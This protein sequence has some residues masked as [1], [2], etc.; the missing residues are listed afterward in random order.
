MKYRKTLKIVFLACII[1][2]MLLISTI[3]AS[4]ASAR[5]AVDGVVVVVDI[6][7]GGYGTGFA[8][9]ETGKKVEYI[10]TNYH[11]VQY[12]YENHTQIQVVFSAASNDIVQAEVYSVNQKKDL[13][14]VKLPEPTDKRTALALCPRKKV[15]ID[16]DFTAL[17]FPG[18]S[19]QED[20]L[21]FDKSSITI[22]SAKIAKESRIA[23][24]ECYL[25]DGKISEGNSGGP[26]VNAQGQV[27]GINSFYILSQNGEGSAVIQDNYAI[28]VD[29]LL[30]MIDRNDIAIM[31]VGEITMLT[32]VYIIAAIVA[33]AIIAVVIVLM[34]KKKTAPAAVPPAVQ[35]VPQP[36]PE[37]VSEPVQQYPQ[38]HVPAHTAPVLTVSICGLKGHFAGRQFDL[39]DKIIIGRDSNKCKI[40]F[41][42]DAPGI[43]GIH[44]EIYV[45][46]QDVF[47]KDLNSSYGTFLAEGN[48]LVPNTATR[49]SKGT[50]FYVGSEENTFEIRM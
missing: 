5:D 17:G 48:K 50:V 45:S 32:W 20:F 49:V 41:P 26:L 15:D 40:A 36:V 38:A 24:T 47:L 22:T 43:S 31:V 8:I 11:V 12:A 7:G 28:K 16:G 9:G 13:A 29:E 4:A 25:I 37:P 19:M 35:P 27:V 42:L 10:V 30:K 33:V 14:I 44:C 6:E 18:A 2:T 46:S 21:K 1:T 3:S 39:S 23:E 34:I